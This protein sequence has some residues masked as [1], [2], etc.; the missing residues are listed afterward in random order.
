MTTGVQAL[1][2]RVYSN[3]YYIQR[4][5]VRNVILQLSQCEQIGV[6]IGCKN[7]VEYYVTHT[8]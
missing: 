3:M 5:N 7:Y 1:H 6:E 2:M 8:W 4:M